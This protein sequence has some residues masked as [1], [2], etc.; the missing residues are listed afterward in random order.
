MAGTSRPMHYRPR[1][2]KDLSPLSRKEIIGLIASCIIFVVVVA[3][4]IIL[5]PW[6]AMG[7]GTASGVLVGLA[8][9]INVRKKTPDAKLLIPT[10]AVVGAIGT[11]ILCSML[12]D[13]N[14]P[15]PATGELTASNACRSY[16]D[17]TAKR[18]LKSDLELRSELEA[19]YFG[20]RGSKVPG[21]ESGA[22]GMASAFTS[23]DDEA[24]NRANDE[25]V[26]ACSSFQWR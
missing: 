1:R 22:E 6:P 23:G 21:I 17:I 4:A 15:T 8:A 13:F 19:L 11:I 10:G 24:F 26:A 14:A 7:V 18:H 25:F 16:A 2:P 20:A 3:S 5:D 9:F 12:D